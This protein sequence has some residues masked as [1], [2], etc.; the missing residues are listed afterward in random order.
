MSQPL[1]F[2]LSEAWV[3]SAKIVPANACSSNFPH[4]NSEAVEESV[5]GVFMMAAL[6][7]KPGDWTGNFIWELYDTFIHLL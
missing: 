6:G 2:F 3:A 5:K 1:F 7:P 4:V